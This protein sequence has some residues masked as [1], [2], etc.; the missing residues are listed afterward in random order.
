MADK[1]TTSRTL[2]LLPLR[3]LLVFP[4]T[5]V[6]L[7][8]GREKS[9]KALDDAMARNREIFLAAQK[10]PKSN[11]PL[12]E[13]IYEFGTIAQILQLLRLPDG[14]VK[15]LV[16]GKK[17]G[18]IL[19]YTESTEMLVVEVTEILEPSGRSAENEALVRTVKQAFDTYVKLNKKVPPE[20]VFSISS[21]EDESRLADTLVVQLANLKLADKQRILETVDPA[22][23]LEEIFSIIQSEIEILRVEKKIRARVKRQME[24]TQK[25]Y[26]L[27]EQMNAIQKE[28]GNA[29]DIRTEI[30]EIESKIKAKKLSDEARE[31]LKK[32][33]KKL[34]SMSPMS[35][36]ATVV[37]N[38]IDTVLSLPWADYANT[39]KD[40]N[41]AEEVLNE[42][43]FGLEKV[44]ERILEYLA[45]TSLSNK[46]RGPILCLVGPPGVGKTSLAKSVARST[47]RTFS[48]IALGGV[49]DEAEIRGHRRT[50]IGAMPGKILNAIKKAGS[51]NPVILL[52]EIDKMSSDFRGDPSSAM[53]EVLDPEQN[54]AFNDHYLDLDYDLSQ[55]LFIATAN[56]LSGVPKP[57]LDRMEIIFLSGYTEQEKIN[58]GQQHLI[59]K[60]IKANGLDKSELKF[61][62]SALEELVRYYTREAGVR[63]LEREISSVCRKI[64]RDLLKNNK[65]PIVKTSSQT[66]E[67]IVKE[68]SQK[69]T[70]VKEGA[71]KETIAKEGTQKETIAKEGAQKEATVNKESSAKEI[72]TKD[73]STELTKL[74]TLDGVKAPLVDAALV[75]KYLGPRKYSIGEKE[76]NNEIGIGQ[77]LAYTEVGGDL[78]V[79]EVAVMSGKG[80]LKITGKLGDVMQESAQAAFSYVRS[81]AAF[82]GLEEEFY[83]KIDIHVHFP[84]GAIP[85]D[86]PSAGITMAT[87]LVSALT[88]KPFNREVAMTGEITLRGRVL[89]IGGLK[90]KLLAAHRG[91]IKRVIIPKEN[92]RDL[93]EIPKNILEDLEIVTVDHM[94]TV[95]LHAIA[96]EHND[97]LETRLKNSQ[98]LALAGV[99][100]SKNIQPLI[101]H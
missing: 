15:I 37:R 46:I 55:A 18:R 19:K 69:E 49:R 38:Y 66:K 42:D 72:S 70:I 62:N 34:R 2:P 28:L 22:K 83:S 8:V 20:M 14:T 59:Q 63:N 85:K 68:G 3:E 88:K 26:Y 10:K 23:R 58:I 56:N 93:L 48:R 95:L 82:L 29:D 99:T 13:E 4:H 6:P 24:K 96:W 74:L 16:E 80:N 50:Y 44:K 64:A 27:N 54:H 100:S 57:L 9:I 43:H 61:D 1:K 17:R 45:V 87:A 47:G 89:P 92:E 84:E 98:A 67:T 11:D 51:G 32:E 25:E 60:S 7:F 41:Y 31:K 81:R 79:T 35:A 36:E 94:D 71:Q 40:Q 76:F 86:G 12:P 21:I 78:L 53:L 77:G 101:H 65:K 5:V 30:A 52:D 91:G 97:A 73:P 90:E 75:Q 33:V 39:I